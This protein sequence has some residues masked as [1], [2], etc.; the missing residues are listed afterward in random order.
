MVDDHLI[1]PYMIANHLYGIQSVIFLERAFHLSLDNVALNICK[2][3]WFQH[4]GI[5]HYYSCEEYN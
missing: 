5:P 2:G 4:D 1:G 3:M